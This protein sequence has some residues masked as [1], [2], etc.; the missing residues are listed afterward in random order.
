MSQGFAMALAICLLAAGCNRQ[1]P[2][3]GVRWVDDVA[4]ST[5]GQD[6]QVEHLAIA[7]YGGEAYTR[8]NAIASGPDGSVYAVGG[9][10]SPMGSLGI[11]ARYDSD[12]AQLGIAQRDLADVNEF[13]GLAV[14]GDGS[15]YALGR[16][17][18]GTV[19]IKYDA[20]LTEVRWLDCGALCGLGICMGP[21][22]SVYLAGSTQADGSEDAAIARFDA[23]LNELGSESWD[24]GG[25]E[26]FESLA[27]SAD[28]TVFVTGTVTPADGLE[29]TACII[30]YG[31]SLVKLDTE[32]R[33]GSDTSLVAGLAA[34]ADG[35]L[36]AISQQGN[37]AVITRFDASLAVMSTASWYV[38]PVASSQ[39]VIESGRVHTCLGIGLDGSVYAAG[40]IIT[41]AE[42]PVFDAVVTKL[43][44]KL[45]ELN[46][47]SWGNELLDRFNGV[48]VAA[49]GTVY[50]AG[51][52]QVAGEGDEPGG[53]AMII[54]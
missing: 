18:L 4:Y 21:D 10:H 26:C 15:V 53:L 34:A 40:Y 19:I 29:R 30:S 12:L 33:Y 6:E 16:L 35:T 27:I 37:K 47:V 39:I 41:D 44:G 13:I 49:D 38:M 28:G 54:K 32:H 48:C 11:V 51:E 3:D 23:D 46:T 24:A 36:Y 17:G 7:I 14:A 52:T 20:G 5:L 1:G 31:P 50:A 42:D 25:I 22:G 2:Y 45:N 8:F 43:D 9:V